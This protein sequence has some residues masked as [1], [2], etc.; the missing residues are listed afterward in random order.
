MVIDY[1]TTRFEDVVNDVDIV[2]DAVG[3]GD[4]LDRSWAVMKK[5]GTLISLAKPLPQDQAAA[6][7]V[8]ASFFVVEA[9]RAE[10]TQIAQLIDA[11]EL[12][13]L[14]SKVLPLAQASE[15]YERKKGGQ[16]PG[17]IIL[18]VIGST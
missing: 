2:L 11:G 16:T 10:L 7:G 1:T 5:G 12:R 13:P 8:R 14:V 18:Q 4:S 9:N 6:Y 3:I 15:A 17:K